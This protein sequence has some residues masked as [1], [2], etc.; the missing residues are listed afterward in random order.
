MADTQ[1]QLSFLYVLFAPLSSHQLHLF[2]DLHHTAWNHFLDILLPVLLSVNVTHRSPIF[3]CLQ[4]SFMAFTC[5]L[6]FINYFCVVGIFGDLCP[7]QGTHPLN[8]SISIAIWSTCALPSCWNFTVSWKPLLILSKDNP[9]AVQVRQQ[10]MMFAA[11][12]TKMPY[13]ICGDWASVVFPL[14]PLLIRLVIPCPSPGDRYVF[15]ISAW[16]K[17]AKQ[18]SWTSSHPEELLG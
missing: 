15:C 10:L 6:A 14:Q 4:I 5:H 7:D 13:T 9:S 17:L 16:A 12:T 1:K 3:T 11:V 18:K 8:S 2:Y